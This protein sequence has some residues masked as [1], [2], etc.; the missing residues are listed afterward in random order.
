MVFFLDGLISFPLS[1]RC[2]TE[3]LRG[4]DFWIIFMSMNEI[5]QRLQFY[6]HWLEKWVINWWIHSNPT[7]VSESCA[8]TEPSLCQNVFK[9]I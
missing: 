7:K 2:R 6:F 4:F 9:N 5:V 8:S 3:V 1:S